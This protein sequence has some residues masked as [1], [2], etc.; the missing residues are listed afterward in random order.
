MGE[1][2]WSCDMFEFEGDGSR[3]RHVNP[4]RQELLVSHGFK[5]NDRGLCI[6]VQHQRFDPCLYRVGLLRGVE[7]DRKQ[8]DQREQ[9]KPLARFHATSFARIVAVTEGQLHLIC[10]LWIMSTVPFF[11]TG[12]L[13][14]SYCHLSESLGN[15]NSHS[16]E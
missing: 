8:K 14:L 1:R 6:R 13:G 11:L 7:A 10:G 16:L 15:E 4:D 2:A 12:S 3:F 9:K 5:D